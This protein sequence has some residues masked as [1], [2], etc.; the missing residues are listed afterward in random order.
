MLVQ[1]YWELHALFSLGQYLEFTRVLLMDHRG[2]D[3]H[4][5]QSASGY[6]AKIAAGAHARARALMRARTP[7]S[8]AGEAS[9]SWLEEN[10]LASAPRA[11]KNLSWTKFYPEIAASQRA[12]RTEARHQELRYVKIGQNA[13]C[14]G[15][16]LERVV[17]PTA[18]Q[19]AAQCRLVAKCRFF[20]FII[21][22]YYYYYCRLDAKCRF[23]SHWDCLAGVCKLY[24]TALLFH[25]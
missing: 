19:C 3:V 23:F 11:S 17:V 6:G 22:Y 18:D 12:G 8:N 9:L 5:Q 13:S 14:V 24:C 2:L 15:D 16:M 21:Y 4:A 25:I 20:I 10:L 7:M 1:F